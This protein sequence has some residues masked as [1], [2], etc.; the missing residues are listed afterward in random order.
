MQVRK[1]RSD[2]RGKN[3]N[4]LRNEFAR[5]QEELT[6]AV[7]KAAKIEKELEAFNTPVSPETSESQPDGIHHRFPLPMCIHVISWDRHPCSTYESRDRVDPG[8]K[9][10]SGH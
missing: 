7:L 4:R 2:T 3:E 5:N 6:A 10:T 9:E 8:A 1:S